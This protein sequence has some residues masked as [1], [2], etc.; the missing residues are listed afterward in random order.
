M[1][2]PYEILAPIGAGGMGE[3]Y[4]ARDTR[5][6]RLVAI[7]ISKEKFSERFERETRSIAALNHPHICQLHDVGPDYLVMEYIE[8]LPLKGPLPLDQAIK[9]AGQICDALDAAHKKGI[10]HRDLKPGN[11]MVTKAG[12]KLLDFGLARMAS[13]SGDE[14]VTMAVMGTP[15]YM[16]PEQW[17]GKPGDARSDLYAFGCVL[18]EML[19]GKRATQER[20][21][22]E[23]STVEQ[24]IKRCLEKDRDD[25]WQSAR[26]VRHA[27]EFVRNDSS[28]R[29][30]ATGRLPWAGLTTAAVILAVAATLWSVSHGREPAG[31]DV[32]S[33]VVDPPEKT[34]FSPAPN[35][36]V[37]VPQFALSPDAHTLAFVANAQGGAPLLWLRSLADVTARPLA[38][39]ENAQQP[40]WS[41]DNRWLGFY[42][43]GKVKKV[44][45]A[46]GAVQVVTE[47]RSDFRGGAWGPDDT[48]LFGAGSQPV[49]RVN[50][51]GGEATPVTASSAGADLARFPSFLPDGRHFVYLLQAEQN[52]LYA[53]SLEGKT[54]KLL[55]P[56][57]FSAVYAPSG[58]LLFVDGHTLIAQGFD[59]ERL[60]THGRPFLVAEHAGHTTAFYSGVSASPA[61]PIAYADTISQNG[62][63]TWF[64]RAGKVLST[65]GPEGEYTDFR[66]APDEKSFAASLVDIKTGTLDIWMNDMKRN[67]MSLFSSGRLVS[68]S[69]VWA[70]DGSRLVYRSFQNGLVSFYRR[71]AGGAGSEES[72]LSS[73][74][75]RTAQIQST[76]LAPTD[77][78]PDGA[79]IMFSVPAP[80]TGE[81]LWM[82][83]LKGDRKPFKYI[84][85][86][87]DELHG[88]FSP[89]GHF[90]AYTSN[91]SGRFEVNVET[92]PRSDRKWTV[93]NNGGYEPRWRSDG[94]EIFYLSEDHKLMAVRVSEGTQ[95]EAPVPLF[96]TRVGVGVSPFRTHYVPSRDGQRFLVNTLSG[97]APPTPIIVVLNWTAG[98]KK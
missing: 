68:A 76:N 93:S 82:F 54:K 17:E 66:L 42:A 56:M 47:T 7:K 21:A 79:H 8:G 44:P 72:V 98:L 70:P 97:D 43:D 63:L 2:G 37:N 78:S 83:P 91:E 48:I 32:V 33:F 74:E 4:K 69:A 38:G 84:A 1:L 81:D 23:P 34:A 73:E 89:D 71:S 9:Y 35:T 39:T 57:N 14:T 65:A 29:T 86:P 3:V 87:A 58:Y 27:L 95:F 36:T 6:D 10:T 94:R 26:D 5:L 90:V 96:Q 46:G 75:L 64:D 92:Y 85:S 28:P 25:R 15:A 13:G 50:A 22:V 20:A 61:G 52:G 45:A 77:W 55:L 51:Q 60:E 24:V 16:S 80:A 18:Y 59:A 12:V 88:N 11:I 41:P 30:S 49:Y 53:G 67:N 31:G 62:H 19:S 40:F